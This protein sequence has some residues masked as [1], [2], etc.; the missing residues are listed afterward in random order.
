MG[1]R[2]STSL[3]PE[4]RS[5]FGRIGALESW[6]HT[7]DRAARTAP[8][9]A[10]SMSRF[11]RE[12]DPDGVLDPAER[13]RRAELLK[14]AYFQ[15]LAIKSARARRKAAAL[16]DEADQADAELADGGDAA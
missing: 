9:R 3:T 10:S 5:A 12:A 13:Q 7:D 4:E 2:L 11:E 8:A 15:R 1:E 6:A 16:I 14:S